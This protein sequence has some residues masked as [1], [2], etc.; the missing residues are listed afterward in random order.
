MQV[1]VQVGA[2][3]LDGSQQLQKGARARQQTRAAASA[4]KYV[5]G[6]ALGNSLNFWGDS[7][8][9]LLSDF[10]LHSFGSIFSLHLFCLHILCF[11]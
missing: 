11:L 2:K 10:E 8:K 7:E 4:S 3:E 1:V 9:P 6:G 5:G